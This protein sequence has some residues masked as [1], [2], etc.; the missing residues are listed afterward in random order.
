MEARTVRQPVA[1]DLIVVGGGLAGLIAAALVAR[2]GRSVIVLERAAALGG[3]AVT[4]IEGGIHFNLGPHALY[5]RGHAFRVLREL[6]VRF[7]GGVPRPGRAMAL[8]GASL[9]PLPLGPLSLA[10]SRLLTL[11]EKWRFARLLGRL[12]RT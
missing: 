3:R 2:A 10:A 4:Q 6:G 5:R 1:A 12:A 9:A 11:R 7:T 8:A